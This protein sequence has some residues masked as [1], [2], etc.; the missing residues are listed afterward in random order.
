MRKRTTGARRASGSSPEPAGAAMADRAGTV[1]LRGGLLGA[2]WILAATLAPGL[3][4]QTAVPT[5]VTVRVV[6]NDAKLIG[7]GVGG[8]RITI[9]DDET[10]QILARGLHEGST[11]DTERIMAP[12]ER[13]SEV[14]ATEG[15]A[16]FETVLRLTGPRR[17]EIEALGPLGTPHA[18]QRATRTVLLV[19]GEDLTGDGVVLTLYGFT[20]EVMEPSGGRLS[21]SPGER[22]PL[23]ARVTMLCGC[24]T[25]PGGRWDSD[26]ISVRA[27]W[28]VDREVVSETALSFAGTSSEYQATLQAPDRRGPFVLRILATDAGRANAGM[29]EI[30]GTIGPG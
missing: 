12:R 2:A 3:E 28:V 27:Q 9:R 24:P 4:A 25:E 5:T 8:A 1:R 20:V 7:T 30:Q 18:R 6:S 11:G 10:G 17:V 21:L 23:R 26:R 14:F 13:G 22:F 15:A 16:G 19:P 29:V